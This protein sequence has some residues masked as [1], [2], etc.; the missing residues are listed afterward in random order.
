MGERHVV[1]MADDSEILTLNTST[2]FVLLQCEDDD[3]NDEVETDMNG[4]FIAECSPGHITKIDLNGS[5]THTNG[6][7]RFIV[8]LL[9]AP[10]GTAAGNSDAT[11]WLSEDETQAARDF[12]KNI[13]WRRVLVMPADKQLLNFRIKMSR[14]WNS[15]RRLG[16]M[17]DGDSLLLRVVNTHSAD[18]SLVRFDG[19]IRTRS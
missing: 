15:L 18:G 7:A 14:R 6:G 2:G 16:K 19:T 8:Q 13:L 3:P 10:D 4:T 11:N 1:N 9:K 5:I 12:K 17:R